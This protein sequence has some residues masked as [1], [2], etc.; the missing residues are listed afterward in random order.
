TLLLPHSLSSLPPSSLPP[1]ILD[2]IISRA[3]THHGVDGT[4]SSRDAPPTATKLRLRRA[5]ESPANRIG[6]VLDF[7]YSCN[8]AYPLFG[9][10]CFYRT[11]TRFNNGFLFL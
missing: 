10:L 8:L 7:L 6:R 9:G 2:L 4:H 1:P 11:P 5:A 3:A